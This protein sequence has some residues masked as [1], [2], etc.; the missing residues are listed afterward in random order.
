MRG[1]DKENREEWI[2]LSTV[3]IWSNLT[4]IPLGC[5]RR[6]LVC[7]CALRAPAAA[8]RGVELFAVP[9]S[10]NENRF[11]FSIKNNVKIFMREK[12]KLTVRQR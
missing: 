5:H 11:I 4:K 8:G 1:V 9:D 6:F 7:C 3:N 10:G 12:N 2:A